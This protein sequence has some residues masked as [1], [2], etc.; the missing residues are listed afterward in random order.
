M[1]LDKK[2]FNNRC[3]EVIKDSQE[4]RFTSSAWPFII[5]GAVTGFVLS[6]VR[7]KRLVGRP[8]LGVFKRTTG[9]GNGFINSQRDS[10]NH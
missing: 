9:R 10:K 8:I 7:V 3:Q 1:Y 5:I 6:C 2:A 4:G